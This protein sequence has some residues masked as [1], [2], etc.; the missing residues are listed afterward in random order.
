[1]NIVVALFKIIFLPL[2]ILAWV[3]KQDKKQMRKQEAE[4]DRL[5]RREIL[6][7]RLD[8]ARDS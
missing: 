3:L 4:S 2:T 5:A 1:M 8:D 7:R 6:Q